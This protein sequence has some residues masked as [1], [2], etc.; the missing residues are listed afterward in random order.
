MGFQIPL[1]NPT[2]HW[3]FGSSSVTAC[4]VHFHLPEANCTDKDKLD[5]EL[6]HLKVNGNPELSDYLADLTCKQLEHVYR[7]TAKRI[8]SSNGYV[9][10]YNP[11]LIFC[12]GLHN[13]TACLGSSEQGKAALF[14][15]SSYFSKKKQALE[16]CLSVLSAACKQTKKFPSIAEDSGTTLRTAQHILTHTLNKL[17]LKMEVTD[18]QVAAALLDLPSEMC[19]DNFSYMKPYDSIVYT[20]WDK[21]RQYLE[22]RDDTAW[23]EYNERLDEMERNTADESGQQQFLHDFIDDDSSNSSAGDGCNDNASRPPSVEPATTERVIVD[24]DQNGLGHEL[25]I[26]MFQSLGPAPFYRIDNGRTVAVPYPAHYR[27]RGKELQFLNRSE[28]NALVMTKKRRETHCSI[29]GHIAST[30]FLYGDSYLLVPFYA[31]FLR[32]KQHILLCAGKPPK[33]PGLRPTEPE[34]EQKQ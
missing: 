30:Q 22:R 1:T 23:Q 4:R 7:E 26:D 31:Q 16:Q 14:Y 21:G 25:D 19:S 32:S 13:N 18:Y 15:L 3:W 12:T 24:V 33:P 27:F 2:R 29:R 9:V 10:E 6:F 8:Q 11:I 17:H 20:A 5:F 28:Y 34:R